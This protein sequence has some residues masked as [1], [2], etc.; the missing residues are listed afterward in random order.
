MHLRILRVIFHVFHVF[1][2]N[3]NCY[4]SSDL[5]GYWR[6][7]ERELS[8]D[9]IQVS[10]VQKIIQTIDDKYYNNRSNLSARYKLYSM[11]KLYRG[12]TIMRAN[13]ALLIK[14]LIVY[15]V[16]LCKHFSYTEISDS[17]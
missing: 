8:N 5:V 16:S 13:Y 6:E 11:L 12:P 10:S 14:T 4:A 7:R 2:A 17:N 3:H 9:A 1:I 15:H